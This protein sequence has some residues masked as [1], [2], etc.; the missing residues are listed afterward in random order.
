MDLVMV[1]ELLMVGLGVFC[2]V[3]TYMVINNKKN[4]KNR[5]NKWR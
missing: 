5:K 1:L 2:G 3:M 4:K